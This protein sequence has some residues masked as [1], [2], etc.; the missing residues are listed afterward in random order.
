MPNFLKMRLR[1]AL[2]VPFVLLIV[3]AVGL[4]GY[5]SFLN[6]QKAVKELV[7]RL[8]NEASSR[9]EQ[10]LGSY[11]NA[12]KQVTKVNQEAL[13]LGL[14]DPK[15]LKKQGQFYWK[16]MQEF[17]VSYINF[18]STTGDYI[19][20]GYQTVSEIVILEA[21]LR[22]Y[23]NSNS[24]MYRTD[25]QGNRLN[26]GE[27]L[28]KY[29]YQKE[30]WYAET[31]KAGKAIWSQIYQWEQP[32]DV[33]SVS[34]NRPV[35]DRFNKI[36][37]VIGIDLRLPQISDFLAKLKVSPSGKIFIIERNGL[38]V[39]SSSTEPPFTMVNGK[40]KRLLVFDSKDPLIKPTA[41]YLQKTFPDFKEINNSQ[42]LE[43]Q[44]NNGNFPF[45]SQRQFI[46]VTPWRDKFGLDWLIVTVVPESDF[47]A[48]INANN[49]TTIWLS[50]LALVVAIAVAIITANWISRP[51][52]RIAKASEEMALGNFDQQVESSKIIELE[53]LANSFNN[54]AQQLKDSFAK[55]NFVI[56][57]ANQVSTQVS[58]STNQI[59]NSGKHLEASALQQAKSIKQ[60]NT[61][62]KAIA[63][64]SGQ[65]VK[66]MENVTQQT[67]TTAK[68]TSSSQ[69]SLTEMAAAMGDLAS[70]TNI[71][72]S[73][74]RMMNE[75][76]NNITSA[77]NLILEV[78]DQTNLISLNAAIEAEKAGEYGAGF[79]IVAKEVRR[80]ADN[81]A[82]TSEEI[83]ETVKEI[84]SSV[85]KG[86]MEV[87]KFSQQVQHHIELVSRISQQIATVIQQVQS[88]TPQFEQ[89]KQSVE[90]QFTGAQEISA[91]ISQLSQ[92]S[93]QTVTSL[94]DTNHALEQLN[95]T[96]QV[97]QS[98]IK[99]SF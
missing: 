72:S 55:L 94:Q 4:V 27:N 3:T 79:A 84:Q 39:A 97:L 24:T 88:L 31:L 17:N 42:Q 96:A 75:K 64:T 16:Q 62:A 80:L 26:L 20:A 93:Q 51:I 8:Q 10:H 5:L 22:Q 91:T 53:R 12:A 66:T 21:S 83:E 32:P 1:T 45:S 44:I 99:T 13:E 14:L 70:A 57:Q 92:V 43:F 87:D 82:A 28:G 33:I 56:D 89:A 25:N 19:G 77:V 71:I 61:T 15:D 65:L 81:S 48:Q 86:V 23:G 59:T 63:N 52:M 74:L 9:V 29:E 95:D 46:K 78:A 18:G 36:I 85:Y 35:L 40:P 98:L 34:F 67:T 38:I 41:A 6:G 73:R 37:G 2:V 69:K 54:M 76:A 30:A 49:G 50:L 68:A 47:M 90:E 11:L 60:V 7:L 58:A